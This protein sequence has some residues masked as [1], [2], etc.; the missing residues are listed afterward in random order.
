MQ[1]LVTRPAAQA[2]DWVRTLRA[3]GVDAQALPLI[4]IEPQAAPAAAAAWSQLSQYGLLVF[5]SPNAVARF[6]AL[7]PAGLVWPDDTRVASTGPGTTRALLDAGVPAA[8]IVEPAADGA[9]FDSQALW[10]QLGAIPWHGTRVLV[11][12]GDGGRDWLAEQLRAAGAT[13]AFVG[14]YRRAVP[15]L[16]AAQRALLADALAAPSRTV[17]LFSSS[18][19]VQHLRHLAPQASWSEA[20]A[21]ATHS[22]IAETARALGFGV[23]DTVAPTLDAVV[24][25]WSRSI[26]SSAP[27]DQRP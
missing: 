13:V 3:R 21:W 7:K 18:Q 14:L 15:T 9:Q 26:Q 24:A 23:V 25:A 19:A 20:T 17:W 2:D 11:L 5:V 4:H 16:S 1:L 27:P 6:F 22:R 10:R 12:R 8:A